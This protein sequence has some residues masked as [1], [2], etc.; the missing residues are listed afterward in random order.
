MV[1]GMS[2]PGSDPSTWPQ[3]MGASGWN[4]QATEPPLVMIGDISC[5]Q[6]YV[7]TPGG[8]VPITGTTWTVA[9]LTRTEQSIPAW[10]IVLTILFFIVCL[11]GLL[12]L[13]CKETRVSGYL[14]VTVQGPRVMH[15][16]QIP[17]SNGS[18]IADV[19]AWVSYAR[20]LAFSAGY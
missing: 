1:R 14:Q 19:H 17:M 20:S 10:A 6:H 2:A 3:P 8:T 11:L 4:V 12:F 7:V 13:L 16:T 5:T 15:T 18:Q 9:D